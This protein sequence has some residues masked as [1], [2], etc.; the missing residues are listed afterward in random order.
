MEAP[1]A[2]PSADC[3][4]SSAIH[5]TASVDSAANGSGGSGRA[6]A[7]SVQTSSFRWGDDEDQVAESERVV[8]KLAVPERSIGTKA[9][10]YHGANTDGTHEQVDRNSDESASASE[11]RSGGMDFGRA[12]VHVPAAVTGEDRPHEAGEMGARTVE[13]SEMIASPTLFQA[14]CEG[15][16]AQLLLVVSVTTPIAICV[17]IFTVVSE[18]LVFITTS[19][20]DFTIQ[21][22]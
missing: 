11:G 12:S 4:D 1:A 17:L 8:K 22:K 19:V 5:R 10:T 16:P 3:N 15:A 7:I 6:G 20:A 13:R 21:G 18:K 14:W 2:A 9:T